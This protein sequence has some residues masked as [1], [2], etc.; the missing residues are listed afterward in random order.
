MTFVADLA[1]RYQAHHGPFCRAGY[2]LD[3]REDRRRELRVAVCLN[4]MALAI[5]VLAMVGGKRKDPGI[6][7]RVFCL[8]QR[9]ESLLSSAGSAAKTLFSVIAAATRYRVGTE[10][11][12]TSLRVKHRPSWIVR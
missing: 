4:G 11:L 8:H 7:S 12:N 9:R 10:S 6:S 1:A 2:W 3:Q 5:F